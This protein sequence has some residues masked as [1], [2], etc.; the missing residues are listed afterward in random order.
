MKYSYRILAKSR[1]GNVLFDLRGYSY[2]MDVT[3][4]VRSTWKTSAVSRV[5]VTIKADR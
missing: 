1:K 4:L 2:L 3:F 5:K